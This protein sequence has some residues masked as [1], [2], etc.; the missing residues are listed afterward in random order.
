MKHKINIYKLNRDI[1]D[2]DKIIF[3]NRSIYA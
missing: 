2:F 3:N 1:F